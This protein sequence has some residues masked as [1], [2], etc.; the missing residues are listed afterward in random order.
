MQQWRCVVPACLF[1]V[2]PFTAAY[3][4]NDIDDVP[5]NTAQELVEW[6]KNEVE[7][8]YLGQDKIPRNWRV[9]HTVKGNYLH[10]RLTFRIEYADK[11]ADCQVRR[12]A[13]RRYAL[14]QENV[15]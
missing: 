6:C 1:L 10:V 4:H 12:G 8:R 5:I 3:G 2:I 13:Q 9:S 7:Q 11:I 15:E 14:F